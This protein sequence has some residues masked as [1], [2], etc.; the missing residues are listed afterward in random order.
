MGNVRFVVRCP[1]RESADKWRK[2]RQIQLALEIAT[3]LYWPVRTGNRSEMVKGKLYLRSICFA[4][5]MFVAGSISLAFLAIDTANAQDSLLPPIP[6]W[7]A[8]DGITGTWGGLRSKL[9]D[10]GFEFIG[11]Y[12]AEVWGNTRG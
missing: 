2:L 10:R 12:D 3:L 8:G 5:A 11:S 1:G 4:Q 6:D 7:L 9:T